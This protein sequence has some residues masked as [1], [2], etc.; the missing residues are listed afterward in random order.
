MV[1]IVNHHPRNN[2]RIPS[3]VPPFRILVIIICIGAIV[4]IALLLK[5]S[6]QVPQHQQQQQLPGAAR[7]FDQHVRF[8][9]R[10]GNNNK[11]NSNVQESKK[12]ISDVAAASI[13]NKKLSN[14]KK[15]VEKSDPNRKGSS[16][17]ASTNRDSKPIYPSCPYMKLTDLTEEERY[18][19]KSTARHIVSPPRDGNV[20]LVCCHTTVGPWNILVH[21]NWAPRGAQR[22]LEMVVHKYFDTSVPLM[23]CI[24]NFICQFGLNGNPTAMKPYI[25]KNTLIDDPS[26]LPEGPKYRID[27]ITKIKRFRRGYLAYAGAGKDSRDLQFIVALQ[28]NGPLGGGSPWEV[29]WGELVGN[30]SYETLSNVYTGYDEHGPSQGLLHKADALTIVKEKYPLLD[31]I[32]S[33]YITD[34]EYTDIGINN[35]K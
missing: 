14:V 20:T 24:K 5:L 23:R 33:C 17:G 15:V 34:S 12:S 6:F 8:D 2:S 10:G 9:L 28:D 27:P 16:T 31:Y 13:R 32:N 21:T 19:E 3:Y 25:G 22:F 30:H 29:P 11:I 4:A 7:L 35:I 1:R 26:W 18:P